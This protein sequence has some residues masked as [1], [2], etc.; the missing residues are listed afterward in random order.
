MHPDVQAAIGTTLVLPYRGR[1]IL[2]HPSGLW[3]EVADGL[4]EAEA[5]LAIYAAIAG[6][7]RRGWT[8]RHTLQIETLPNGTLVGELRAV[9]WRGHASTVAPPHR[10]LPAPECDR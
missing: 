2:L 1:L 8:G 4:P 10:P 3:T 7:V 5:A 9:E 6:A